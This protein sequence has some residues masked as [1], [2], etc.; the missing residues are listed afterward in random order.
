MTGAAAALLV[1]L[2]SRGVRVHTDGADLRVRPAEAL[3]PALLKELRAQK[4]SL[5]ALLKD[6][7]ARLERLL[8]VE[9]D[10]DAAPRWPHAIVIDSNEPPS[11][12]IRL[13]AWTTVID[14]AKS[15]AA[16]LGSLAVAVRAYTEVC[17]APGQEAAVEECALRIE[18]LLERLEACGCRARV[19]AMQ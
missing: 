15:V 16:D 8:S 14:P 3:T 17:G 12:P 11:G 2:E 4:G 10:A 19:V 7:G 5:L 1:E 6:P 13:N 9:D 18:E